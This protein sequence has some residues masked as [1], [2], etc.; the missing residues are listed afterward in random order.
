MK[1]NKKAV[2]GLCALAALAWSGG[3]YADILSGSGTGAVFA[4]LFPSNGPPPIFQVGNDNW[5]VN[6]VFWGFD[7]RT[8]TV[9]APLTAFSSAGGPATTLA[10]GTRVQSHYI[11]YDPVAGSFSGTVLFANPILGV[12]WDTTGLSASDPLFG[13]PSVTYNSVPAT[14][15]EL[16]ADT[17]SFSGSTLSVNWSAS[18]P[19]DSIRVLTAAVPEPGS[20]A[21]MLAGLGAFGALTY[22][23]RSRVS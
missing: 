8:L 15:L 18:N 23:R 19:G 6:G 13:L 12:I 14:G 11:F 2:A 5:N 22:R 17:F 9:R 3:A 21:M 10:A 16:G 7:E 4:K 1:K 20:Y